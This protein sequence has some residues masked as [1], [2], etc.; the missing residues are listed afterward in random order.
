[1]SLVSVSDILFQSDEFWGNSTLESL[2]MVVKTCKGFRV[3]L[4]GK[5]KQKEEQSPTEQAIAV[6]IKR[7]PKANNKWELTFAEARDWFML[8]TRTMV[9]FCAKFPEDNT[10]HLSEEDAEDARK[11]ETSFP[12]GF[13]DAYKLTVQIGLKAAMERRAHLDQKLITSALESL[14]FRLPSDTMRA[15][16]KAAIDKLKA[17]GQT[18]KMD[19]GLRLL[20]KLDLD[21]I[22]TFSER[23][24]I[25]DSMRVRER[26]VERLKKR[27]AGYKRASKTLTARYRAHSVYCPEKM[28]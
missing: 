21:F 25:N 15:N 11:G 2:R 24:S 18:V 19:K 12:I 23:A 1:M 14:D 22:T 16:V 20:D 28:P 8:N 4:Q 7:R 13:L 17:G 5:D 9:D 3:T 6:M 27:I 26:D 10:F